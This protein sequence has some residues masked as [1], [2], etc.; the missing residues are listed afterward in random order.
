MLRPWRR[1]GS[2]RLQ[3]CR[4]FDVDAVRFEPPEG[5]D[6]T[7]FYC[8]DAPDWVNV[9][10]VTGAGDVLF[11]RQY[12]HGTESFTLEIPGGMCDPDESPRDAAARE[13]HEE[14]GYVAG[15]LLDLG[16]VHPNPALQA[17]RCHTFLARE[18]TERGQPQPDD[19]EQFELE[20]VPL[21]RVD[22]LI[23]EGEI[24]HALV[25]AAF[26]LLRTSESR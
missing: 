6:P 4:V 2:D 19:H 15:A 8:L 11:V 7:T 5:G 25:I 22:R 14:T 20:R 23:A 3:H 18:L 26:H 17:N 24:T 10:P 12:R 21:H 1:V 9:I 16:F 13:L